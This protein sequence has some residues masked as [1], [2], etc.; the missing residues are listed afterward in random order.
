MLYEGDLQGNFIHFGTDKQREC[1]LQL[2]LKC[3]NLELKSLNV[4]KMTVYVQR[5]RFHLVPTYA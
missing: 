1:S 3:K 4:P 5:R 2:Y